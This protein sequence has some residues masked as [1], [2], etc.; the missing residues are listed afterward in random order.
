METETFLDAEEQSEGERLRRSLAAYYGE[1]ALKEAHANRPN[2]AAS[3]ARA[4]A[5]HAL[6]VVGRFTYGKI[7]N[8]VFYKLA[9]PVPAHGQCQCT[10]L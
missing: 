6:S 9:R 8:D 10:L 5:H 2:N 1:R 7:R 4:S 3:F